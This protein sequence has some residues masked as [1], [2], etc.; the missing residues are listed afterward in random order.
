MEEVASCSSLA[1]TASAASLISSVSE[2]EQA[3]VEAVE[4]VSFRRASSG[5]R[6]VSGAGGG[7]VEGGGVSFLGEVD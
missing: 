7:L 2:E 1:M 5:E 3:R 6:T 4:R